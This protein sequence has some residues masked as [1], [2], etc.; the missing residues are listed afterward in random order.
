MKRRDFLK[1]MGLIP[2]ATTGCQYMPLEGFSNPCYAI[3]LPEHL[4]EHELVAASWQGIDTNLTWDVHTHLIGTGDSQSGVWVNPRMQSILN[5]SLYTQFNFYINGSCASAS[6]TE[7]LDKSYVSRIVQLHKDL[8]AGFRFMLLA[9][10]YYHDDNGKIDKEK[11]AFYTPNHYAIEQVKKYPEQFEWIASIHP[12][13]EDC[14]EELEFVVRHKARAIKW[15]PGAM[16]I[17]PASPLCDRFY[18]AL[19]KHDIPLLTHAGE[20]HA[21][22]VPEDE[23]YENPLLFRHALERGVRVIFAHCATLGE[24]TDLD[25]GEKGSNVANVDLFGR[26]MD[27]SHYQQQVYGDISAITQVNRDREVIE[28]IVKRSDWHDRLL[29]GSDYPLPG[30]M[31]VFSPQNY[32][33]WGHITETEAELLSEV[34]RYNPILFDFMLKRM[35]KVDGQQFSTSV[36]ET[37]KIFLSKGAVS[38]GAVCRSVT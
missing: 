11:S 10:D 14:V 5:L 22:D 24:S 37:R 35:L 26:L 33:R 27:E 28:K 8:P 36:F 6:E 20:E 23:K 16:G 1:R 30:V 12:Y 19:A 38:T 2:L 17:N 32:L 21:V 31:P 7:T 18:D 15:L 29:Y 3:Q 9:F 4:R 13:R 34:R 25:K